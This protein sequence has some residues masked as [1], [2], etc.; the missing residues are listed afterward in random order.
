LSYCL[1][2]PELRDWKQPIRRSHCC[3]KTSQLLG[4]I[5]MI[6]PLLAAMPW[7]RKRITD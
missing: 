6:Q 5:A 7:H 1:D 2:K 3:S 4:G